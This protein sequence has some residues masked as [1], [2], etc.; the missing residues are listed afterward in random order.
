MKGLAERDYSFTVSKFIN[1]ANTTNYGIAMAHGVMCFTFQS[2]IHSFIN[3]LNYYRMYAHM[4]TNSIT[5]SLC[6]PFTHSLPHNLCYFNFYRK[7]ST[8]L[9]VD[10]KSSILFDK[11]IHIMFHSKICFIFLFHEHS[12]N[13]PTQVEM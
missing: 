12:M 13:L 4:L 1:V 11:Q 7:V 2:F 6:F 8:I 3:S 5:R 10:A 9:N